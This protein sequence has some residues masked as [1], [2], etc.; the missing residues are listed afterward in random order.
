[1]DFCLADGRR[2]K[3]R[4]IIVLSARGGLAFR[5]ACRT[6]TGDE[7][8]SDKA[9]HVAAGMLFARYGGVVCTM[10]SISDELAPDVARAR[11]RIIARRRALHGAVGQLRESGRA[12]FAKWLPFVHVGL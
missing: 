10:W 2:S 9:I 4:D 3:L 11:G 5:S 7:R 12:S 1:M 8:L 6:A